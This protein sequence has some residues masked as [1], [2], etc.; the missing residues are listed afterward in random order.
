MKKILC[1]GFLVLSLIITPPS[2]IAGEWS[3]NLNGVLGGKF[4][5]E[6]DWGKFDDQFVLVSV[7]AKTQDQSN[8]ETTRI[9]IFMV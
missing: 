1:A 2:S 3:Y 9:T 6:D 5:E 7:P 8:M 4:L